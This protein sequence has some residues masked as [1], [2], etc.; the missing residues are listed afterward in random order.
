MQR[1]GDGGRPLCYGLLQIAELAIAHR[2]Q[3]YRQ[4]DIA[5][6][7]GW[8]ANKISEF[9]RRKPAYQRLRDLS[10]YIE[11]VGLGLALHEAPVGLDDPTCWQPVFKSTVKWN[12]SRTCCFDPDIG[13]Y[14]DT[15]GREVD[16]SAFLAGE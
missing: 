3:Y 16:A 7:L 5:K 1:L 8:S 13:M 4:A 2:R 14:F 10:V 12:A 9:E 6:K 11:A 15:D